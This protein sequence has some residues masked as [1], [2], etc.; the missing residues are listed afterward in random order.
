MFSELQTECL[1]QQLENPKHREIITK[2]ALKYTRGT[3][4]SWEDAVQTA[5]IK[6]I[7]AL[8][9][10][11]FHQAEVEKFYRWMTVVVRHEIINFVKKERSHNNQSLDT[12]IAGTDLSWIDTIPSQENI[13]DSVER[14]DLII[15]AKEAITVLD[16][17]YPQYNYLK[18]WQGRVAFKKQK[19]LAQE[20]GVSQ[21]EISRRWKKLIE[22]IVI[23]LGLE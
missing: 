23:E 9:T 20:L 11:Q 16:T 13:F 5:Y 19:Y 14:A 22:H 6:V 18:L 4:I 7:K 10:G 21:G 2:I 12:T 1:L 17:H 15:K 8:K 3:S